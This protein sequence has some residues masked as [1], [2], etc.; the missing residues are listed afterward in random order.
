MS[1]IELKKLA[2]E[3]FEDY[4]NTLS[5]MSEWEQRGK[6]SKEVKDR[7]YRDLFGEKKKFEGMV[8]YD[9]SKCVAI[10]S[11]LEAYGTFDGKPILW[12]DDIFVLD[13]YRGK[14]IGKK[15]FLE[16]INQAKQRGCG[17]AEWLAFGEGPRP[18][19]ESFG[20]KMIKEDAH[21]RMTEEQFDEA[22]RK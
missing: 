12:I 19:Y 5:L 6:L 14:G 3:N 9:D 2:K 20:A 15:I 18:F 16:C 21:Y 1:V 10:C 17:R 11:F 8:V 7:L 4:F 13:E 22:L